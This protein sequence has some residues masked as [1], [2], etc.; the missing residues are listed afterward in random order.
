[1]SKFAKYLI[2]EYFLLELL[3]EK[4]PPFH[5]RESHLGQYKRLHSIFRII[6]KK[7]IGS[8]F[9]EAFY[10]FPS[11]SVPVETGTLVGKGAVVPPDMGL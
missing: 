3:K 8:T 1:M 10:T 6:N 7:M 11:S 2:F 4:K 9:K 5:L